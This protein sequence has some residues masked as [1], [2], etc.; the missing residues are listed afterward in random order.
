MHN[1]ACNSEGTFKGSVHDPFLG[2][3]DFIKINNGS[4]NNEAKN[5]PINLE[6]AT[7]EAYLDNED[8][9]SLIFISLQNSTR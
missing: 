9:T 7:K 6:G 3:M 1:L 2:Q 8:T 5:G 4:L